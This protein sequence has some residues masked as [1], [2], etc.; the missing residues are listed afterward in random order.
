MR[1]SF[2]PSI[3]PKLRHS[4]ITLHPLLQNSNRMTKRNLLAS[5]KPLQNK[6]NH[7]MHTRPNPNLLPIQLLQIINLLNSLILTRN[8][9]IPKSIMIKKIFTFTLLK[10][11]ISRLRPRKLVSENHTTLPK[12]KLNNFPTQAA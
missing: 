8:P 9:P 3:T 5:P 7:T 12:S 1:I 11:S 4:K 2:K 10:Q 6:L